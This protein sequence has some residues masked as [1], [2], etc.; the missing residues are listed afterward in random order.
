[1][2]TIRIGHQCT[3]SS[4]ALINTQHSKF[5]YSTRSVSRAY[6]EDLKPIISPLNPLFMYFHV[7]LGHGSG[8][9]YENDAFTYLNQDFGDWRFFSLNTSANQ[10]DSTNFINTAITTAIN[11]SPFSWLTSASPNDQIFTAMVGYTNSPHDSYS[12]C[13]TDLKCGDMEDVMYEEL[14]SKDGNVT[15][16]D[17]ATHV[18]MY[19]AKVKHRCSPGSVMGGNISE[20]DSLCTWS[21]ER[22]MVNK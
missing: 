19:K 17:P 16:Y 20:F 3:S 13:M 11:H 1:M 12:L 9:Y 6:M 14:V 8:M 7:V 2:G 15:E 10:Q 22:Q 18:H 4:T 21:R 5:S